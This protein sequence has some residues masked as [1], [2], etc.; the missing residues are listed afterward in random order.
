MKYTKE[1]LEGMS[2][3]GKN[4]LASLKSKRSLTAGYIHTPKLY[5]NLSKK[6]KINI[7]YNSQNDECSACHFDKDGNAISSTVSN[8]DKLGEA[9]VNVF[10]MMDINQ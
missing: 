4:D 9:V 1:Q 8:A 3:H 2:N 6:H 5:Y 7:M 10:L